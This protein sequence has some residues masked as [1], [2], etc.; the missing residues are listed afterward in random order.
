MRL[1]VAFEVDNPE[2]VANTKLNPA[3]IDYEGEPYA[4]Y[5]YTI[6]DGYPRTKALLEK[7]GVYEAIPKADEIEKMFLFYYGEEIKEV[8]ITE[9]EDIEALYNEALSFDRFEG[10]DE[11]IINVAIHTENRSFEIGLPENVVE[12]FAEKYKK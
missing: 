7:M 10:S 8:E 4:L 9:R 5:Q 12:K 6:S 3:D 11:K 1:E 2:G